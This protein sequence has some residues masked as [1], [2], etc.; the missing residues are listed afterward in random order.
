MDKESDSS[1]GRI[2][3]EDMK[4]FLN[5]NTFLFLDNKTNKPLKYIPPFCFVLE[6]DQNCKDCRYKTVCP[7]SP[8]FIELGER[9]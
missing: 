7:Y 4:K 9:E 5:G 3:Y 2:I 8:D 1:K 6:E